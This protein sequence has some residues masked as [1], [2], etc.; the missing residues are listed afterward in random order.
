MVVNEVG[1]HVSI[2]SSNPNINKKSEVI[3]R[4]AEA[5]EEELLST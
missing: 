5:F 1:A 3:F 4:S 2:Q